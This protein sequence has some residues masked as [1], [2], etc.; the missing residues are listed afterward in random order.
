MFLPET[1]KLPGAFPFLALVNLP[2]PDRAHSMCRP[3]PT[4]LAATY[5]KYLKRKNSQHNE[6]PFASRHNNRRRNKDLQETAVRFI[7]R[8]SRLTCQSCSYNCA[9]A[10]RFADLEA[11]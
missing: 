8:S 1:Q 4:E 9:Q 2:S 10:P 5:N 3:Y 11:H 7:K 6:Q